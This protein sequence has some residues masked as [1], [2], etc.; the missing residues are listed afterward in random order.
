MDTIDVAHVNKFNGTNYQQWKFQM[1][2]ALRAKGIFGVVDGSKP[3]PNERAA[4]ELH[5]KLKQDAN[6]MFTLTSA[7]ELQQITLIENCTTAVYHQNRKQ[8]KLLFMKSFISI[9]CP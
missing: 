9:R 1:S 6:A 8:T 2:C 7:M 3:K 5:A 4:E